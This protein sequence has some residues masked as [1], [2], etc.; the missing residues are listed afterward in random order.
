M[1]FA[2]SEKVITIVRIP[3][4]QR[5]LRIQEGNRDIITVLEGICAVGTS[6][7]PLIIT[8]GMQQWKTST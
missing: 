5:R 6:L 2:R 3:R 8:K 1:G 7:E 4:H